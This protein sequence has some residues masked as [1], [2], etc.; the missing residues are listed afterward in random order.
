MAVVQNMIMQQEDTQHGRFL[1]F[2]LEKEVYAIEIRHVREIIGVLSITKLPDV[3]DYLKGIVNLR[4][5]IVPVIDV[6]LL[7]KK[8]PVSY[9]EKTCIVV[10]DIGE[11]CAG[12]IVDHVAEVLSIDDE[13]IMPPPNNRS[14][15]QSRFVSGIG[16][17]QDGVK[18]VLN[19]EKLLQIDD[20]NI[21]NIN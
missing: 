3:P 9:D 2:V 1:T 15:I 19:C 8:E 12:L 18:L 11:I 14:G 4:G 6:R 17:A 13:N 7:F 16:N 5:K 21:K 20:M 10:I